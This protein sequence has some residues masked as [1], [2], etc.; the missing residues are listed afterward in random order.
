MEDLSFQNWNLD[1]L[2][3][4]FNNSAEIIPTQCNE[5]KCKVLILTVVCYLM[6]LYT[7]ANIENS[8]SMTF[9]Q[10]LLKFLINK[11]EKL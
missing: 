11:I 5:P 1:P 8:D 4:L 7:T 2:D 3:I 10:D 6:K 9:M